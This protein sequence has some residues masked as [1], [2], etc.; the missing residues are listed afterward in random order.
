MAPIRSAQG[1]ASACCSA[2][3]VGSG[4]GWYGAIRRDRRGDRLRGGHARRTRCG[5][6]CGNR[7]GDRRGRQRRCRRDGHGGR[8][9]GGR[10]RRCAAGRP[11]WAA[12]ER[13]GGGAASTVARAFA[14]C[15]AGCVHPGL[16]S[17]VAVIRAAVRTARCAVFCAAGL[18]TC[19]DLTLFGDATTIRRPVLFASAE[20]RRLYGPASIG[21]LSARRHP[22]SLR[23]PPP[24]GT[25]RC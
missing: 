22:R 14:G 19:I 21:G 18:F 20:N 2:G 11:R 16:L 4:A 1:G 9:R 6:G 8:H 3:S 13:R 23:S 12:A 10:S 24:A 25:A 17:R 7:G 5:P 15:D